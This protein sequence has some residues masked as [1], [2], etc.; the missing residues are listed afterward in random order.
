MKSTS[1]LITLFLFILI[2]GCGE[3][4]TSDENIVQLTATLHSNQVVAGSDQTSKATASLS[5]NKVS[6]KLS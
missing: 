1:V 3:A 5:L 2:T 6:G 4:R